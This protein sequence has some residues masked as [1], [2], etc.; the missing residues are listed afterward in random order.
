[1]KDPAG[2]FCLDKWT[3][4]GKEGRGKEKD[5]QEVKEQPAVAASPP[6][7]PHS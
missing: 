1:M 7:G 4:E 3:R 2:K 6:V 5:H